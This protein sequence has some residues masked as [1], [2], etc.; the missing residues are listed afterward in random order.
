MH[1]IVYRL[2]KVGSAMSFLKKSIKFFL[3][4]V[5]LAELIDSLMLLPNNQMIQ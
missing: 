4:L 1:L 5:V 3:R 2:N